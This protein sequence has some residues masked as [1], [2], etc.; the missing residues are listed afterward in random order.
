MKV[1]EAMHILGMIK[2]E[3]EKDHLDSEAQACD[4]AIRILNFWDLN[5]KYIHNL[6]REGKSHDT[7]GSL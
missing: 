3:C 7:D 1:V 5:L 2:D 6:E 4:L